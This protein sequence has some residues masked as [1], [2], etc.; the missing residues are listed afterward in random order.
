MSDSQDWPGVLG[1][2][3]P[4]PGDP[5]SVQALAAAYGTV[6]ENASQANDLLAQAQAA[7]T[8]RAM[9][10]FNGQLGSLPG[11]I[12][13]VARSYQEASSAL[14]AYATA[15]SAAQDQANQAWSL[16]GPAHSDLQ[17]A[18]QQVAYW[19]TQLDQVPATDTTGRAQAGGNLAVAQGQQADAQAGLDAA[20]ALGQQAAEARQG[21]ARAAVTT[22]DDAANHSI[23]PRSVWQQISDWFQDNPWLGWILTALAVIL[24]FLGPVGIALGLVAG[25]AQLGS[26]ILSMALTGKWNVADVVLGVVSLIPGL[27]ELGVTR[28]G[29]DIGTA[30]G[31]VAGAVPGVDR[32]IASADDAAGGLGDGEAGGLGEDLPTNG[33]IGDALSNFAGSARQGLQNIINRFRPVQTFTSLRGDIVE[34]GDI[35]SRPIVTDGKVIGGSLQDSTDWT[36]RATYWDEFDPSAPNFQTKIP[37]G[38]LAK[39]DSITEDQYKFLP[40]SAPWSEGKVIFVE[41]HGNK[42]GTYFLAATKSGKELPFDG[43]QLGQILK[44]Q[45]W[46]KTLLK[47]NPDAAIYINACNSGRVPDGISQQLATE[48]GRT[49]YAPTTPTFNPVYDAALTDG[50][51]L[52]SLRGEA[53]GTGGPIGGD[54]VPFHPA[55]GRVPQLPPL[56]LG[57]PFSARS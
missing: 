36:Q 55:G 25:G 30:L 32:G 34:A 31:E 27:S 21:A 52:I 40:R 16:A 19:Q 48:L 20:R 45:S 18:Q 29:E 10:A 2:A 41:G 6:G 57:S 47:E 43:T 39:L 14:G 22:L 33:R 12:Q 7:G 51:T 49:V 46:F 24:P 53:V 35:L 9:T 28:V 17:A 13:T 44:S 5:Q 1:I 3:D 54:I 37:P 38:Q 15:L 4:A 56:D 23:P 42:I 11:H 8:G 26:Q 50:K